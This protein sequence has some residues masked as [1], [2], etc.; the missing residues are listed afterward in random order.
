MRRILKANWNEMGV[1]ITPT[2]RVGEAAVRRY[3]SRTTTLHDVAAS[4]DRGIDFSGT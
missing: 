4:N 3:A 2:Q 1:I